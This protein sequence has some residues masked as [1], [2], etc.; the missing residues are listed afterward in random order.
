MIKIDIAIIG[1]GVVG[2]AISWELSKA[3]ESVFLF[4]KNAGIIKGE[5]QSS[6]NSGVIHSGIYYDQ[7][8]RPLKAD[9][10]VIGNQLLYEFCSKY[11]VPA[12]NTGKL[13][14]ANNKKEEEILHIYFERAKQNG[15]PGVN[16][17]SGSKISLLEPNVCARSALLVPTAGILEPISLIHRLYT[18]ASNNGAHFLIGTKVIGLE[19]KDD[20]IQL[21]ILYPDGKYDFIQSR[22]V[23]NSGGIEADCLARLMNQY[24]QY[25]LDP[26][27]G[28]SYKFYSHKRPELKIFKMNVYPAPELV[29]TPH[30]HHFTVGIHLTPTFN[31]TSYPPS[32]GSTVTIGPKLVP[33]NKQDIVKPADRKIFLNAASKYFPGIREDDL[34]WHQAGMQSRLKKEP[35]FVIKADSIYPNFI[36]LVGIDSPGLTSCIAIGRQVTK[37]VKKIL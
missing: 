23:I 29:I 8:T 18:M 9:L 3:Y 26:I 28:E 15:V 12:L 21:K 20:Y 4:E 5:N 37:M 16:N 33:G 7:K 32:L 14:V 31:D 22:V 10:C 34:I 24:S 13:I 17:I 27:R 19:K 36:N 35:D 6:H 11:K 25:E 1:G 2:C 30:G